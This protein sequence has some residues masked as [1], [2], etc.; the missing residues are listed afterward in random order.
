MIR[1]MDATVAPVLL[2]LSWAIDF[3]VYPFAGADLRDAV[4][5]RWADAD[6][7]REFRRVARGRK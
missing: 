4:L 3:V 5:A 6:E 2:A 7:E 1:I